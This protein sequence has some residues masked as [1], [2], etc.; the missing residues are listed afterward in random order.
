MNDLS[1]AAVI[2]VYNG[3]QFIQGAIESVLGQTRVPPTILVVDD[4]STDGTVGIVTQMAVAEPRLR[5]IVMTDNRGP[6]A[7]RNA[8][9]RAVAQPIVAFLDADDF[10]LPHHVERLAMAL[11]AEPGAVVAFDTAQWLPDKAQAPNAGNVTHR[12]VS[13]L[14][15]LLRENFITQS[16]VAIRRE[17]ALAIGGYREE[18][19]YGEDYDFWMRLALSGSSFVEVPVTGCLRTPHAAQVSHRHAGRMYESAWITRREAVR[20]LYPDLAAL[21]AE[22]C[23][24]L[25]AA[26][27]GDVKAAW[28]SR[29]RDV[30]RRAILATAW[31]PE[32]EHS[33]ARWRSRTGWQWLFW[34]TLAAVRDRCR[35]VLKTRA[36]TA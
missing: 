32:S 1:V 3:A 7:A 9:L 17:P 25:S 35:N 34:R 18:L 28:H 29:E 20:S 15:W 13:P 4:C 6:S 12:L 19:R 27:R 2:P 33:L 22:F 16:A 5:L 36:L 31:V 14:P 26:M 23:D 30:I 10:W 24:A 11:D 8:A 21:P